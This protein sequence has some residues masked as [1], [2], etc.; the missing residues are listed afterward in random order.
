VMGRAGS[1]DVSFNAIGIDHVQ[2]IPLTELS[3]E[4]Y[5]LPIT[6]YARTQ[7]LTTAARGTW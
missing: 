6:T 2:G 5:S 7:F 3:P 4:D 1:I